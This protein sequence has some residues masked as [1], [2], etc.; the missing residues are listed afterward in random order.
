MTGVRAKALAALGRAEE[1]AALVRRD[2]KAGA[3][4]PEEARSLEDLLAQLGRP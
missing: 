2:I 3:A 1:G 4:F